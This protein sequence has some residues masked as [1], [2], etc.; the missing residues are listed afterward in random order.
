MVRTVVGLG[1]QLDWGVV[2]DRFKN[3]HSAL[4][5]GNGMSRSVWDKFSYPSLYETAKTVTTPPLSAESKSLFAYLGSTNFEQVLGLLNSGRAVVHGLNIPHGNQIDRCYKNIREALVD[6]VRHVHLPWSEGVIPNLEAIREELASYCQV[7]TT[8][9]DLLPYWALMTGDGTDRF[10]D[11]FVNGE[12]VKYPAPQNVVPIYYLH[13]AL[14]LYTTPDHKPMKRHHV[15]GN[16]LLQQFDFSFQNGNRPLFVSEGTSAQKLDSIRDSTF[17]TYCFD[18]LR[19]YKGRLVIFGQGLDPNIDQHLID[20]LNPNRRR[21][22]AISVYP[23]HTPDKL[24]SIQSGL[25]D[26][27]PAWDL[28]FF[29]QQT[30]PL[31]V[32]ARKVTPPAAAA[33]ATAPAGT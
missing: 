26:R 21:D 10:K 4:L 31:G 13:G 5:I 9:Y 29:N 33:A 6:A 24:L 20:A 23:P 2:P 15:D 32:P 25:M 17:L 7:F 11:F 8:N 30:H 12:F 3:N 16:S 19:G 18:Q 14:M 1:E 22:V 28:H 27:L